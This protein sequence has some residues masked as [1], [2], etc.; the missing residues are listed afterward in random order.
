MNDS[1]YNRIYNDKYRTATMHL[2]DEANAVKELIFA[3]SNVLGN[4]GWF[5][6]R[7]E[8]EEWINWEEVEVKDLKIILKHALEN[9]GYDGG[10]K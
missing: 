8:I 2:K 10:K 1:L 6:E 3:L 9:I 4:I 5:D 7:E